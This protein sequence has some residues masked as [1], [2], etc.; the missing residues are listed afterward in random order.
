VSVAGEHLGLRALT[1]AV[2]VL[3][4][5]LLAE[6]GSPPPQVERLEV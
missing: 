1:G 4:A 2:L 3:G 6:V 5:M